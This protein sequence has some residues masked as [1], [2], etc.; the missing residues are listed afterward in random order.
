M[1]GWR[2]ADEGAGENGRTAAGGGRRRRG[3]I[4]IT[5]GVSSNQSAAGTRLSLAVKEGQSNR[6][7]HLGELW[8]R[9]I[10]LFIMSSGRTHA[11]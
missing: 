2:D 5:Y 10:S 7:R 9:S 8:T 1:R 4:C 3:L 6:R 11:R